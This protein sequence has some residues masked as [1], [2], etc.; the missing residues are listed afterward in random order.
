LSLELWLSWVE[1]L[2]LP[3]L[4]SERPLSSQLA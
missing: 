1:L 2:P 4:A 3:S